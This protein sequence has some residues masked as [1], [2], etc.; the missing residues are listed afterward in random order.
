MNE[1]YGKI[2]HCEIFCNRLNRILSFNPKRKNSII[3]KTHIPDERYEWPSG[4]ERLFRF[5][6]T[7]N[8]Q[9]P[10]NNNG[11]SIPSGIKH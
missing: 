2:A 10:K 9:N 3:K 7:K 11:G 5:P 6:P 4:S 1:N 8:Q